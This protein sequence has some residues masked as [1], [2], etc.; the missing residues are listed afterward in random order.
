MEDSL[1]CVPI[2]FCLGPSWLP[3]KTFW[4]LEGFTY[5]LTMSY[6]RACYFATKA[7]LKARHY[8]HDLDRY[9]RCS[10]SLGFVQN[11]PLWALSS[12]KVIVVSNGTK[13]QVCTWSKNIYIFVYVQV[14]ILLYVFVFISTWCFCVHPNLQREVIQNRGIPNHHTE[15]LQVHLN[16]IERPNSAAQAL[17]YL[18]GISWKRNPWVHEWT[19]FQS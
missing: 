10:L 9:Y 13:V 2:N 18:L 17:W 15:K 11:R 6:L 3:T 8:M 5:V 4:G 12:W 16:D 7:D 19:K 14:W 1:V